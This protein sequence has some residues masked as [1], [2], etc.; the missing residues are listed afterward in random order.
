MFGPIRWNV[1]GAGAAGAS[2]YGRALS[3]TPGVVVVVPT[4]AVTG[5]AVTL[6]NSTF[7]TCPTALKMRRMQRVLPTVRLSAPTVRAPY[8]TRKVSVPAAVLIEM[9]PGTPTSTVSVPTIT[10]EREGAVKAVNVP[11]IVWVVFAKLVV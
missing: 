8:T 10:L 1:S 11:Q 2:S 3:G 5:V 4:G 7:F 6:T 9:T